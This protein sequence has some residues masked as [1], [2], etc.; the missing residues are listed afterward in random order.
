MRTPIS[1]KIQFECN[2]VSR[3]NVR[4]ISASWY[5]KLLRT[6][7][8]WIVGRVTQKH[9]YILWISDQVSVRDRYKSTWCWNAY[10]IDSNSYEIEDAHQTCKNPNTMTDCIHSSSHEDWDIWAWAMVDRRTELL[11]T[12]YSKPDYGDC[13]GEILF[14]GAAAWIR[15]RSTALSKITQCKSK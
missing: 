4:L 12:K 8:E 10:Y 11:T 3:T 1:L 13:I 15:L 7:F 14:A 9:W 6:T 2:T 5:I